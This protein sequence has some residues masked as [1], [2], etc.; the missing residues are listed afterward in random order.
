MR[1]KPPYGDLVEEE[2]LSC[3]ELADRNNYALLKDGAIPSSQLP[4]H[5]IPSPTLAGKPNLVDL[6][7]IPIPGRSTLDG[8]DRGEPEKKENLEDG[9]A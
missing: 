2:G 7:K 6:L 9:D 3:G 5:Q 8:K 4:D 1:I